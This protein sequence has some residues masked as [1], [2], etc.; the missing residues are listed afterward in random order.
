[1]SNIVT[2]NLLCQY[3]V[4]SSKL[5]ESEVVAIRE[6]LAANPAELEMVAE[7]SES[8][9]EC[10]MTLDNSLFAHSSTLPY[11]DEELAARRAE[12]NVRALE[13][14]DDILTPRTEQEL[15]TH[16][17]TNNA[18][19]HKTSSIIIS[20]DDESEEVTTNHKLNLNC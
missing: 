7:I 10:D 12:G 19:E 6:Y 3:I 11:S 13:L 15:L 5:S 14:L 2:D 1:M 8:M 4:D 9:M 16:F 18:E 17:S 20:L